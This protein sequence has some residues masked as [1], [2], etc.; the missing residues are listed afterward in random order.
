MPGNQQKS[1]SLE[2]DSDMSPSCR[3][4]DLS[5]GGSLE[6]RS[7]SSRSRSFTLD[8]ESLKHLT[9]EEKDVILFF[10]ETL[11]SLEYDFDEPALCDS[12]IHCH[13]PQSLEESPSSHSEPEDV[14][15]LVQ[16]GPVS[17]EAGS[18]ADVPQVAGAPS[19]TKQGSPV[20]EGGKQAAENSLPPPDSGDPEVFSLPLPSLPSA[21]RKE[22]MPPSP[23]AEHPKLSRSVPTPL[24]IAHKISE[25]LAGNEALSPTSPSK[26]GRPGE[27]RTPTSITSRNGDQVGVW[28]RHTAQPAPK[29]HRFP[30]NICVTN[31]AGKDFN[32]T[33]SKAA[34]NVQERKAQVLANI[35]GMSF[36][37]AGD[38]SSEE[39]WQKAEE[40]RGGSGDGERAQG[41]VGM[42]GE[43]GGPRAGGPARAQQSRAVQTEQPPLANG[44]QSVHEAL[45][46]EP[47]PFVPTSKTITFRP[48]P[49]IAG[50]LARQNASRSLYEPRLDSLQEARKR[51]GSL[52]RAAGF[53]PHGITVQFAGRGSTEEARREALRKLG[54]L[55]ENL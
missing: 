39:R 47:S 22:L 42:A 16:P 43:P 34:V 18:L 8:D 3:L 11:D 31:S 2:M 35:N 14:I 24:V 23:P 36:I 45:R 12:G 9:H 15:D 17:G 29:I 55:K 54:L 48:D 44:F 20:P 33:I 25:K 4:S 7:S 1:E 38:T 46:S 27:W 52:P 13:S 5:R 30:S 51:T 26:E 49:A 53:R 32:K 19:A 40:Q 28:H 37:A 10:E 41:R 21:P 50:K 6:S